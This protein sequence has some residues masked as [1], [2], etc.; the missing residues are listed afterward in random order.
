MT[1]S[2]KLR[3]AGAA[4]AVFLWTRTSLAQPCTGCERPSFA[5]AA[6][7]TS[8]GQSTG[9]GLLLEDFDNDGD[10]DAMAGA[11]LLRGTG[12][13]TFLP[14]AAPFS[15]GLGTEPVAADFNRDGLLDLAFGD[16]RDGASGI[17][18][19]FGTP[20]GFI[21]S[22]HYTAATGKT[23][24]GD[25]NGDGLP[26]LIA[27]GPSYPYPLVLLLNDGS[28]GL[29]APR[30]IAVTDPVSSLAVGDFNGDG[31]PDLAVGSIYSTI[32]ILINDGSGNFASGTTAMTAGGY[33]FRMVAGDLDKD[34]K[35]D[36]LAQI[37]NIDFTQGNLTAFLVQGDGSLAPQV[38]APGIFLGAAISDINGDGRPDVLA[39]SNSISVFFG[40]VGGFD[41][42]RAIPGPG[43]VQQI[44]VGDVDRDGALDIVATTYRSVMVVH[45]DGSGWFEEPGT[46]PSI[47]GAYFLTSK[48]LNGD[49]HPDFVFANPQGLF[50]AISTGAGTFNTSLVAEGSFF[51]GIALADI[52][53]DGKWDIVAITDNVLVFLGDGAGGFS[54][55]IATP[56]S[57]YYPGSFAVADFNGDGK[58]DV[59]SHRARFPRFCFSETA[60]GP[61]ERRRQPPLASWATRSGPQT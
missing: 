18:I 28:G 45:G 22:P 39:T 12:R 57:P 20:G 2:V 8:F 38:L 26:D 37:A 47:P 3:G 24:A 33:P 35:S 7:L 31:V 41:A 5:P 15:A 16:Y 46:L 44:T 11:S 55:P 27:S 42:P 60:Q 30:E 19:A 59:S 10:L 61:S 48:E 17:S 6:T 56:F 40:K 9:Y 34:G 54:P 21:L 4:I 51:F 25:F 32:H 36:L 53:G 50:A 52:N 13:G 14:P 23:V 43:S 29:L 1:F 58:P 49:S